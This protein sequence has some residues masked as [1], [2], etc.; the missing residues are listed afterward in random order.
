MSRV[1]LKK[2]A[3]DIGSDAAWRTER[4]TW[5]DLLGTIIRSGERVSPLFQV[6]FASLSMLKLDWLHAADLGV[7]ADFIG[8]MLWY[9]CEKKKI[10]GNTQKARMHALWLDLDRW[11][12]ANKVGTDRLPALTKL[13]VKS[14]KGKGAPK[15]RCGAGM[16]RCLVP[17]A[18]DVAKRH[19]NGRHA[20]E[21]AMIS[22][23]ESLWRCYGALDS[24]VATFQKELLQTHSTRFAL[25]VAAL[26]RILG[27]RRFRVKPKLHQFLELCHSGGDPAKHW[28]YRDE[29]FGGSVA[30]FGRR[31]GGKKSLWS[32]SS[33][34]LG[35]FR[36]QPM[37]R[38]A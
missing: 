22:A 1:P 29:D 36:M 34:T 16:C 10:R 13:T 20:A 35:K 6:P 25:Q 2:V 28:N 3:T 14:K 38:I 7:S 4:R 12:D 9:I 18:Y 19:L 37:V 17:W 23:M 24:Q 30:A 11:Y 31:R 32:F 26:E 15:L 27:K 33:A 8:S 5:H 21:S